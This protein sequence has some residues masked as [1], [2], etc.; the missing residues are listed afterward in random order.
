M[1][2]H[3]KFEPCGADTGKKDP[4][5]AMRASCPGSGEEGTVTLFGD[6]GLSRQL[7]R[8]PSVLARMAVAEEEQ[9]PDGVFCKWGWR[10]QVSGMDTA[11]RP[12]SPGQTAS[13]RA[14][15]GVEDFIR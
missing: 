4:F 9:Q 11:R 13:A 1:T 6:T 12:S 10:L 2:N 7:I 15:G 3:K 8:I 5:D 14:R